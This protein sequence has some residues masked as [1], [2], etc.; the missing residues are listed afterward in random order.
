MRSASLPPCTAAASCSSRL[1]QAWAKAG[2]ARRLNQPA[3]STCCSRW[4]ASRTW[5]PS[6]SASAASIRRWCTARTAVSRARQR[7][8][9]SVSLRTR[10]SIRPTRLWLLPRSARNSSICSAWARRRSRRRRVTWP[11]TD[12]KWLTTAVASSFWRRGSSCSRSAASSAGRRLATRLFTS[13][14]SRATRACRADTGNTWRRGTPRAAA[15]SPHWR[16]IARSR[17]TSLSSGSC[18]VS[19]LF[20]TTK[21]AI[22]GSLRCCCHT[23]RS[24]RVTPVSAPSTNSA[25]WALGSRPRVSSGSAPM[26]FRPGVSSTTR[27]WRSSGCGRLMMA[28]RQAGTSTQPSG[29]TGGLSCGSSSDHRPRARASSRVTR[30]VRVTSAS[31]AAMRSG[32]DGS[33]A[34]DC[35][36]SRWRRQSAR[37]WASN[38][39][40]MGSRSR[41]G[42]SASS[43]LS[44]T[45]HMVVRP[46]VAGSTR[47]PASAK[48]MALISSDLPRENSAT[49]ATTRRSLAR[50]WRSVAQCMAA[51]G[52]SRSA[53]RRKRS[54]A[55]SACS[56]PRRHSANASRP[57]TRLDN[58]G[59]S[60]GAEGRDG[61]R[62]DDNTGTS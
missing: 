30:R 2:R 46:G 39:V 36:R 52:V 41:P 8:N 24:L 47:R 28:W 33:S 49:K 23:A 53:S 21:R 32:S 5:R 29:P 6:S 27:P 11:C 51:S 55:S 57:G 59:G 42:G 17:S 60:N 45:G 3:D 56:R 15:A 1:W 10:A 12:C 13:P 50:R 22:D 19:T 62:A 20:N 37:L 44:S 16:S 7:L 58:S 14:S 54:W 40:S 31:T 9:S 25:A 18:R 38:R 61:G 34:S 43:Q 35:Q 26:A 4:V 48:K